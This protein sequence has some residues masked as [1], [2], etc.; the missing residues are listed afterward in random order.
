MT[1]GGIHLIADARLALTIKGATRLAFET[2]AGRAVEI[3]IHLR[4]LR[5]NGLPFC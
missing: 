5:I 3:T 4:G 2:G 1:A